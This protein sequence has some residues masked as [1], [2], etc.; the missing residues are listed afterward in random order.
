MKYDDYQQFVV[1]SSHCTVDEV[2]YRLLR[3]AAGLA[4]EVRE[5]YTA[6]NQEDYEQEQGDV[7]FWVTV[8]DYWLKKLEIEPIKPDKELENF[9]EETLAYFFDRIEKYTRALD[10]SKLSGVAYQIYATIDAASESDKEYVSLNEVM[11][12]NYDKLVS[13]PRERK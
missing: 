12:R 1:Q 5:L 3:A 7:L 9:T 10:K 13:N 2:G 6:T 11:T 4:A 8:L